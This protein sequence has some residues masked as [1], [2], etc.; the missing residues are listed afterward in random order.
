MVAD[1][2]SDRDEFLKPCVIVLIII[3]DR[4][5]LQIQNSSLSQP[6]KLDYRYFSN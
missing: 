1:Y 5:S 2:A 4:E 6:A 3:D